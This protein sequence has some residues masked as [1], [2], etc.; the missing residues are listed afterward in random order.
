MSRCSGD[1][2]GDS[3]PPPRILQNPRSS[4]HSIPPSSQPPC[5]CASS[6]QDL[7]FPDGRKLVPPQAGPL[8]KPCGARAAPS[9]RH[10]EDS[11]AQSEQ[12]K[13]GCLASLAANPV[14]HGA[15]RCTLP[16]EDCQPRRRV[17]AGPRLQKTVDLP[18]APQLGW[19]PGS[20]EADLSQASSSSSC[21]AAGDGQSAAAS[22]R[23]PKVCFKLSPI[24]ASF[25][26]ETPCWM[27]RHCELL[28]PIPR[29][30]LKP[31][32]KSFQSVGG[33]EHGHRYGFSDKRSLR[34]TQVTPVPSQQGVCS[35]WRWAL[36]QF[37][38][39]DGRSGADRN[40]GGERAK[41]SFRCSQEFATQRKLNF[42][43]RLKGCCLNC[44]ARNHK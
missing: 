36:E 16:V 2:R 30:G 27:G 13:S 15:L 18:M 10:L 39:P 38:D 26:A 40:G 9:P 20:G 24:V 34:D 37:P 44:L 22:P 14:W 3:P 1:A 23:H 25:S 35:E 11:T 31:I 21:S 8:P 32:L 12:A 29:S 6:P 41:I 19:G 42:L 17:P 43:Q 28:R 5:S 7:E 4:A 33:N